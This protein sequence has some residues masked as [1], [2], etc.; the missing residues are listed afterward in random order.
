MHWNNTINT[1]FHGDNEFNIQYLIDYLRPLTIHT[2]TKDEHVG[3]IEK[4]ISTVKKKQL[5]CHAL[6]YKKY[7][8]IMTQSLVE[9]AV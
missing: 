1:D 8:R 5:M 9:R 6:T 2:Y 4:E 3:F 7:T